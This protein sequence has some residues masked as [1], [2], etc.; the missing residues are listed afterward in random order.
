MVCW[1]GTNLYR[2]IPL[3]SFLSCPL[4][5]IYINN[6]MIIEYSY[7][8]HNIAFAIESHISF[9][10]HIY[11]NAH[12]PKYWNSPCS[13]YGGL[14]RIVYWYGIS[15]L[16]HQASLHIHNYQLYH[17]GSSKLLPSSDR[18]PKQITLRR[19][20]RAKVSNYESQYN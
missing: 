9:H 8:S 4:G 17:I 15:Q 13:L 14:R 19:H 1:R 3:W 20:R 12:I 11:V 10:K 2:L 5:C 18:F 16:T 7:F 6:L